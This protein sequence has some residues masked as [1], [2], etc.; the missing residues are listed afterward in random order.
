MTT[1]TDEQAPCTDPAELRQ[2]AQD[3]RGKAALLKLEAMNLER[4]GHQLEH[5]AALWEVADA[6]EDALC[7][8]QERT[9]GLEAAEEGTLT[10]ERAAQDKLREDRKHHARRKAEVTRAENGSSREAQDEAA[11]RLNRSQKRV[12]DAE[13]AVAAAT[14]KRMAAEVALEAHRT[15]LRVAQAAYSRALDAGFN[16]GS[17]PGASGLALGVS[18]VSDMDDEQR[19]L[20]ALSLPFI[21]AS[22]GSSGQAPAAKGGLGTTRGEFAAMDPSKPRAIRSGRSV[23][24]A[25]PDWRGTP[26]R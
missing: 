6:A 25:M 20:V 13:A 3:S 22:F 14:A 18:R 5:E 9:A 16:P 11:V 15:A 4:Q 21:A 7:A 23:S 17:A 26:A 19:A 10:A 2:R 12:D 8:L 1:G 24:Y